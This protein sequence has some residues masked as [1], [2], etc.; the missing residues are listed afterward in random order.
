[1]RIVIADLDFLPDVHH[2]RQRNHSLWHI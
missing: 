1:M 2:C